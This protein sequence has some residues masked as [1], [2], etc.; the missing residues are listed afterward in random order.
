VAIAILLSITILWFTWVTVRYNICSSTE[1]PCRYFETRAVVVSTVVD[2]WLND[3][4]PT[5]G[6]VPCADSCASNVDLPLVD[7]RKCLLTGIARLP[8]ESILSSLECLQSVL[9][10]CNTQ[11]FITFWI[12]NKGYAEYWDVREPNSAKVF[13]WCRSSER[14]SAHLSGSTWGMRMAVLRFHFRDFRA[15]LWKQENRTGL[16]ILVAFFILRYR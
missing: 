16:A 6:V 2:C 12:M 8:T 4:E 13:Y 3:T 7:S 15:T 14:K 10:R 1:V 11:C 5:L 9:T